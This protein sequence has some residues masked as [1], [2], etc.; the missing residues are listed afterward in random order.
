VQKYLLDKPKI[1]TGPTFIALQRARAAYFWS[2]SKDQSSTM[3][4]VDHMRGWWAHVWEAPQVELHGHYTIA[5]LQ[6]FETYHA[7]T[8][9]LRALLVCVLA[10]LPCVVVIVGIDL[11]PLEPPTLGA[12][13]SLHF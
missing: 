5:N 13:K 4:R 8:S 11:L 6:A 2:G 7:T 12:T 3:G 1:Q 9:W 10:P